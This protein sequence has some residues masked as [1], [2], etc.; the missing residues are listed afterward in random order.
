MPFHI[1]ASNFNTLLFLTAYKL[2][3]TFSIDIATSFILFAANDRFLLLSKHAISFCS[4]LNTL[5]L[6]L[7]LFQLNE[8]NLG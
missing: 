4:F 1:S 2:I 5:N 8:F 3:M 6:A 7:L